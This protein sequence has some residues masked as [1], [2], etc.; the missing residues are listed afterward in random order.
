MNGKMKAF[1]MGGKGLKGG[2]GVIAAI[3]GAAIGIAGTVAECV[4]SNK[5]MAK[6]DRELDAETEEEKDELETEVEEVKAELEEVKDEV[7]DKKG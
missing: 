2:T 1:L 4:I 5:L 7:N 6:A 3:A